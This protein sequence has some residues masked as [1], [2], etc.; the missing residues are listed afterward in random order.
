MC[1]HFRRVV[2]VSV[3]MGNCSVEGAGDVLWWAASSRMPCSGCS[4]LCG[5]GQVLV[6]S[7]PE[8]SSGGEEVRGYSRWVPSLNSSRSGHSSGKLVSCGYCLFTFC[9]YMVAGQEEGRRRLEQLVFFLVSIALIRV[10]HRS[11]SV[12]TSQGLKCLF[13][14]YPVGVCNS[15]VKKLDL[16]GQLFKAILSSSF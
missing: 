5:P 9:S 11:I 2:S 4:H 15:G 16:T 8:W 14:V 12:N 13:P 6:C 7:V 1:L 10:I 3:A